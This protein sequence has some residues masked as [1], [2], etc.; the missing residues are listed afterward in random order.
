MI[1]DESLWRP[2]PGATETA[3]ARC[4]LED[5]EVG[6]DGRAKWLL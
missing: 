2:P 6:L 1:R 3:A 4:G 5:D